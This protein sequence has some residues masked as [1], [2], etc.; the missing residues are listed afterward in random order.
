MFRYLIICLANLIVFLTISAAVSFTNSD[1]DEPDFLVIG[2]QIV[3]SITSLDSD[4]WI[5][6]GDDSVFSGNT[7]G[8]IRGANDRWG[9]LNGLAQNDIDT[10]LADDRMES[11]GMLQWTADGGST[12]GVNFL[13]FDFRMMIDPNSFN[14]D[15]NLNL[16]IF[17]WNNGDTAPAI[18]FENGTTDDSKGDTFVPWNSV[19]LINESGLDSEGRLTIAD[20]GVALF[21]GAVADGSFNTVT[22]DLDFGG[23]YDNIGVLFYGENSVN[24]V[25]QIDNV[26]ISPAIP[27]PSFTAL[28]V[29]VGFVG[30][31]YRKKFRGTF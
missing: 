20:G 1:F 9:I 7:S 16:Y 25:L 29:F 11:Q 26:G 6:G 24:G 10:G 17:G 27:E 2:D 19:N 14:A 12:T 15:Y 5:L 18:D 3:D 28:V 31:V 30:F 21:P 23:G 13:S 4:V 22:V 8:S